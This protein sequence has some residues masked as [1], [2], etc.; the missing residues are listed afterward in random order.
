MDKESEEYTAWEKSHGPECQFNHKGSS[1]D[2]EAKGA[3]AMFSKSVQ[4]YQLSYSKFVG[5]GDKLLGS[6][7]EAMNKK[8]EVAYEVTWKNLLAISR[9]EKGLHC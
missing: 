8:Y 2:M 5:A 7:P 1:G 6:V 9:S 4:K 3:I